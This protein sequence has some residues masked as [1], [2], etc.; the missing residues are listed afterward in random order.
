MLNEQ[1]SKEYAGAWLAL[2]ASQDV[3]T[4]C[5][6]RGGMISLYHV[7]PLVKRL[8]HAQSEQLESDLQQVLDK[9]YIIATGE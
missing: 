1:E 8:S 9:W 7:I 4:V 6:E 2:H 5:V 3:P